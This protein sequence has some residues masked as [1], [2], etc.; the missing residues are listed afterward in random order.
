MVR[1]LPTMLAT[2]SRES[3]VDTGQ[4]VCETAIDPLLTRG[5]SDEK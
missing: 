1:D 2:G 4:G 3:G 5:G